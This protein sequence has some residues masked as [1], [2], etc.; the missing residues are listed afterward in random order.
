MS[1]GKNFG[2]VAKF[3]LKA[4][5]EPTIVCFTAEHYKMKEAN[6]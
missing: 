1:D 2:A 4:D 3:G 6:K 5:L